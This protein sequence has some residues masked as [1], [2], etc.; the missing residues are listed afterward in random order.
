MDNTGQEYSA[1]KPPLW[2]IKTRNVIY[3]TLGVIEILLVIGFIFR[4]L[5]ANPASGFVNFIYITTGILKAPFSGIFYSSIADG[6]VAKSVF[7]P[8]AIIAMMIYAM[9]AWGLVGLLKLKV[10]RDGH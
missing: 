8:A 9:A 7:E 4:L 6:L 10:T 2:Y 5:G 1:H 3:Y